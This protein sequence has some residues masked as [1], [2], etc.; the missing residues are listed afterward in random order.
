MMFLVRSAFWLSL[1]YSAMP[2]EPM[3]AIPASGGLE[4]GV[5][6]AAITAAARC[7][8][9]DAC[10]SIV[11]KAASAAAASQ[12]L[13]PTN[14]VGRAPSASSLSA[15]DLTPVWRGRPPHAGG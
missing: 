6:A 12:G 9:N 5:S 8:S 10:R 1:V 3:T 14:V 13:A 11:V 4:S 2:F 7:A 15:A